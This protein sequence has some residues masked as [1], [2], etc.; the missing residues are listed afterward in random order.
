MDSERN[1][2]SKSIIKSYPII[3][4]EFEG[5]LGRIN[6]FTTCSFEWKFRISPTIYGLISIWTGWTKY[7]I[8]SDLLEKLTV[9]QIIVKLWER[10]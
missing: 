6:T 2:K 8:E 9:V 1:D 5:R 7:K 4:I 10:A 3:S